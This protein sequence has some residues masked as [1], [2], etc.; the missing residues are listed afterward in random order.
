LK[1]TLTLILFCSIFIFSSIVLAQKKDTEKDESWNLIDD[2]IS[3][4]WYNTSSIDIDNEPEL[5]PK[6]DPMPVLDL[7]FHLGIALTILI[8]ILNSKK[9]K[10][11]RLK[12]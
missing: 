12:L 11:E 1:T 9:P 5:S 6:P 2:T 7:I 10:K 3:G 4:K 8:Y